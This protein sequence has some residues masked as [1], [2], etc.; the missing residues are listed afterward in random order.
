[1]ANVVL[2]MSDSHNPFYSS[3]YGHP[4][5]RTPNMMRLAARGTLCRNAYCPSPLCVPSRSAFMAGQRVHALQTY[6][7]CFIDVPTGYPSYGAVLRKQGVHTAYVGK[8]HVYGRS[9]TLGFSEVLLPTADWNYPGDARVSRD[10]LS[11]CEGAAGRA[12]RYGPDENA[13]EADRKKVDAAVAWIRGKGLSLN[14]PWLLTV[15][16]VAPHYPHV[17]TPELWDLFEDGG[18]LPAHGA[19]CAPGRHPYAQ[20]LRRHNEMDLYDEQQ[21]RGSRRGYLGRIAWVDQQLGR[22]VDALAETGQLGTT[23]VCYTSDH[24]N[25]IGQF[26]LW[27]TGS[28]Y[29]GCARVPCVAAGPDFATGRHVIT[30][31]DLHDLRASIFLALGAEQPNGWLGTPIQHVPTDDRERVVFSEYHGMGTRASYYMLRRGRWKYIRYISAPNQLFD[32][33]ADPN[34]LDNLADTRADVAAEMERELRRIC[35]P[36]AEN[37]R[38]ESFIRVQ[39]DK[40]APHPPAG[41]AAGAADRI[42][43]RLEE[44]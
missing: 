37:E 33:A 25:M 18:D 24:G 39:L 26:G 7:N 38:A 21:I 23:N 13:F 20:D 8:L 11:I 34:E 40:A 35:S 5:A 1:M 15:N 43:S 29:E 36:E 22:L 16:V 19:E 17:T 14:A 9:D 41:C 12:N 32:L 44:A 31:I 3:P 30:P 6:S 4:Q 42:G 27:K 28:L 10:P 2:L